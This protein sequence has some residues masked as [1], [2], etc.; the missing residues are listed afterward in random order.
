MEG[1]D[2]FSEPVEPTCREHGICLNLD[3]WH[4]PMRNPDTCEL[5]SIYSEGDITRYAIWSEAEGRYVGRTTPIH[6]NVYCGT[7]LITQIWVPAPGTYTIHAW[8]SDPPG[9]SGALPCQ[10]ATFNA[11]PN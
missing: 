2:M 10:E 1:L 6:T 4:L 8:W 7:V 3:L 5:T 11:G 9:F